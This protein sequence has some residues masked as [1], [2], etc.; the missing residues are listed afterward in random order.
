MKGK[1]FNLL[2]LVAIALGWLGLSSCS[3]LIGSDYRAEVSRPQQPWEGTS[4]NW[5]GYSDKPLSPTSWQVSYR[6]Y[7]EFT[8][9]Q[10]RQLCLLRAAQLTVQHGGSTFV[11]SE[12]K[13]STR[14]EYSDI[15]AHETPGFYTKEGYQTYKQLPNGE[16]IPVVQYR[17]QWVKGESIPAHRVKNSIIESS[18]TIQLTNSSQPAGNNHYNA[19]QLLEDGRK[20]W[21]HLP[22]SALALGTE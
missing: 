1:L 21:P 4:K 20:N 9:A 7:N 6:C 2:S 13:T 17:N 8:E 15:P 3:S 11:V 19:T 12:E 14:F 10:C 16:S 5:G 18:M 22:K